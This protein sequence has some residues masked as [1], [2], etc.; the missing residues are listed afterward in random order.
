MKEV[1]IVAPKSTIN[2]NC[3]G[4]EQFNITG[5]IKSNEGRIKWKPVGN[6]V[7][8]DDLNFLYGYIETFYIRHGRLSD[9]L[10]SQTYEIDS[11]ELNGVDCWHVEID[12]DAGTLRLWYRK[13]P[14][15]ELEMVELNRDSQDEVGGGTRL[16][17]TKGYYMG[18]KGP[19]LTASID[20]YNGFQYATIDGNS[21]C[22]GYKLTKLE[23][24]TDGAKSESVRV[25][26]LKDISFDEPR[27]PSYSLEF[28]SFS[29]PDK[30]RFWAD[31]DPNIPYV[32]CDGKIAKVIDESTLES[33]DGARYSMPNESRV[34]IY[35]LAITGIASVVSLLIY[36]RK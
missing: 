1:R 3:A 7:A 23:E 33:M 27:I 9:V 6:H 32:V 17:E 8:S 13:R 15:V 29:I 30:T 26:L 12:T 20:R 19:D 25:V 35:L 2:V 14:V 16:N 28:K 18:K 5:T 11:R 4:P 10:K 31:D 21:A 24:F 34:L 22:I 36:K